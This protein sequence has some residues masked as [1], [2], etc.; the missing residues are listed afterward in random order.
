MLAQR[1]VQIG[2]EQR[3]EDAEDYSIIYN[4]PNCDSIAPN[5]KLA[6]L[7]KNRWIH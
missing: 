6:T 3:Q 5:K 2:N 1:V 4:N 7:A